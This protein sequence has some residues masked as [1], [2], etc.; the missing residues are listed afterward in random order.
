VLN[1]HRIPI[2]EKLTN[3]KNYSLG[4]LKKTTL[5]YINKTNKIHKKISIN[6]SISVKFDND[7]FFESLE[8]IKNS[9][10]NK[11]QKLNQKNLYSVYRF[12]TWVLVDI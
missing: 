1:Y 3:T 6:D 9:S 8:S 10:Y 7:L 2:Q 11:N 5:Y 4:Q 12:L